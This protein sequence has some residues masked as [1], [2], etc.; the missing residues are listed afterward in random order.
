MIWTVLLLLHGLVAA[1]LLGMVTHQAFSVLFRGRKTSFAGSYV[2][3]RSLL[4]TNAIVITFLVNFALGGWIYTRYRYTARPVLED[5]D[6]QA[7]VG[8]FEFKEHLLAIVL[9][10]LP[11]YWLFWNKVPPGERSMTRT[12]LTLF[13]GGGVWIAFLIGHLVNNV[14][15]I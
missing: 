2:A 1:A 8:A 6:R 3:V 5:L 7:Y 11:A 13:V 10:T 15:G 9:C 12:I 4:F 14:R